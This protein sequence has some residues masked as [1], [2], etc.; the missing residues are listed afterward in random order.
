MGKTIR[1]RVRWKIKR[2]GGRTLERGFLRKVGKFFGQ[3][4]DYSGNRVIR[5]IKLEVWSKWVGLGLSKNVSIGKLSCPIRNTMPE[6]G[7]GEGEE[8]RNKPR[9]PCLKRNIFAVSENSFSLS[10]KIKLVSKLYSR[11]KKQGKRFDSVE[12]YITI[13]LSFL[14]QI[15]TKY[16]I[17]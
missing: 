15:S 8:Y 4:E 9:V 14:I 16:R 5:K 11:K 13:K 7:G 3:A 12:F 6:F 2:D 10:L 1:E 17:N